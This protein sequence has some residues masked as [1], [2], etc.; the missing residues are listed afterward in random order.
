VL[1]IRFTSEENPNCFLC[2]VAT[3]ISNKLQI[4]F[5]FFLPEEKTALAGLFVVSVSIRLSGDLYEVEERASY[6][7]T[8]SVSLSVRRSVCDQASAT[9]QFLR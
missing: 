5:S 7:E 3:E 8:T 6:M 4:L 1:G 9:K 2:S